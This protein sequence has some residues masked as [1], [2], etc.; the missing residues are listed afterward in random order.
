MN[1]KYST[2]LHV[3]VP[4]LDYIKRMTGIDIL[5]EEGNKELAE[6]KIMSLTARARDMLFNGKPTT[7]Q[8][9]ISYLI[10]KGS[11][12][13]AWLNY[14]V[15][16]IEATFFVGDESSWVKMPQTVWTAIYGS[17]LQYNYFS[18]AIVHEVK[19]TTEV[20]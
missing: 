13:D 2:E 5:L 17:Q 15:R 11:Y 20:F 9:I 18:G 10:Y 7:S 12:L 14:V 16:Y 1:S 19:H 3:A 6:G 4:T 8:R